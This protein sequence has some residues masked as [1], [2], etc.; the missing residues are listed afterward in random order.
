MQS[1]IAEAGAI[2]SLVVLLDGSQGEEAQEAAAEAV[3]AL[4]DHEGPYTYT[5]TY[6]CDTYTYTYTYMQVLALADHEDNRRIITSS[7]FL[8]SSLTYLLT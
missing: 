3:L 2:A 7:Y 8:P 1:A 4:A 6:T 5:Y